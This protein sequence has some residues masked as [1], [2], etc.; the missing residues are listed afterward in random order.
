MSA[1]V[2][3]L[4]VVIVEDEAP[5]R[6]L[7]IKYILKRPELK[8]V[9]Y[10]GDGMD[11]L[12]LLKQTEVDL[13]FLD[14][15]LPRMSGLEILNNL[16]RLPYVIFSTALP[17]KAVEAYEFGAIDYLLKPFSQDR[18]DKSVNRALQFFSQKEGEKDAA[19]KNAIGLFIMEKGNHFLVPYSEIIYI[20]S[21][22]NNSI[23]HTTSRD[24]ETYSSLKTME[25]RLPD[26]EFV[27]I[28]KK[29][30]IN[31]KFL[32]RIE[33]DQAGNYTV[34]LK[35]EDETSLPVGRKY[36]ARIKELMSH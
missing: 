23:V 6:D 32:F 13:V 3:D 22:D 17:D 25:E 8:L 15:N 2:K 29:F 36:I 1:S 7:L 20:T 12:E 21:H 26:T 33:S 30:I 10:S 24:Y 18:F 14:I 19:K 31:L 34:Y 28:Y 16:E 27:R 4:R 9:G 5:T 11:A 35:D